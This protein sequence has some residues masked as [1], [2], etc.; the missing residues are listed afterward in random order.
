MIDYLGN[1]TQYKA[2]HKL[3]V[4]NLEDIKQQV[5]QWIRTNTGFLEDRTSKGFWM[6]I[7]YKDLARS[8][9]SLIEYFKYVRI[10]IQEITVGVL[11]EAMTK[12]FV[13]HHGAPGRNFKINF[14][15]YNTEGV[16]TEWYDIP[17]EK[18]RK[19]PEALNEHTE[20][21]Y[22]YDLSSIHNTVDTLY[23]LR[24]RYNMHSCPIVFNSYLPHRVMPGPQAKHPR[25]MLAT[26]PIKDPFDLMQLS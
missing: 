9:P 15:I 11:T 1:Q 19:F 22:C 5:M 21:D 3:P 20:G 8:A 12:G 13:L 18:L 23:P 10:P 24:T 26:M 16:Y 4:H 25:I 2:V 14:P 17:D 6:T 7:D